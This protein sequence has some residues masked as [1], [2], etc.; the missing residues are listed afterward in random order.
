MR[1]EEGVW[2]PGYDG[3]VHAQAA[4]PFVPA[5]E[6]IW[7]MG[8]NS[9]YLKKAEEDYE[10]RTAKPGTVIPSNTT[11]VFVTP[12]SWSSGKQLVIDA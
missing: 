6:S 12:H 5:G 2:L 1:A 8:T 10:K 9:K 4:T 11:F 7:E 3:Q